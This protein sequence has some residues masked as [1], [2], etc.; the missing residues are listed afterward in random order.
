VFLVELSR[1]EDANFALP[2]EN[3]DSTTVSFENSLEWPGL[4][5]GIK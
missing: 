4:L 1:I 5:L 3:S 2:A